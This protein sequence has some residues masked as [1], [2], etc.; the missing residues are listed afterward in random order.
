V[1]PEPDPTPTPTSPHDPT[2][3]QRTGP[4]CQA[5]FTPTPGTRQKYCSPRCGDLSRLTPKTPTV[6]TCPVCQG[7]FLADPSVRQ[8]Y[9]SRACRSEQDRRRGQA[10]DE[11][12]ARRLGEHPTRAY[13]PAAPR[14]TTTAPALAPAATRD[15]PHCGQPVT[16]VA[17]LATP[18]AARPTITPPGADILALRR[19]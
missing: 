2:D 15:C 19:A 6:R 7:E 1:S 10:R 13:T 5:A 17:L 8:V 11:E 18:E 12:R 3:P 14:H 9:C 16:I 4:Q